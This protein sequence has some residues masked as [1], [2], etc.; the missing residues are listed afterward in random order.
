MEVSFSDSR[1]VPFNRRVHRAG[2]TKDQ[3]DF[4]VEDPREQAEMGF[5]WDIFDGAFCPGRDG[6]ENFHFI[7][8]HSDKGHE[9]MFTVVIRRLDHR[10]TPLLRKR[11]NEAGGLAGSRSI[12]RQSGIPVR[13]VGD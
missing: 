13:C 3:Q 4:P 8:I 1:R 10:L 5:S 2:W 6:G 7:Q 11:R 12:L 9:R